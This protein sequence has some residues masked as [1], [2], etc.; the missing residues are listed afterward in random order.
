MSEAKRTFSTKLF[1]FSGSFEVFEHHCHSFLWFHNTRV[2][3][4]S[5]SKVR[6]QNISE[7]SSLL[8]CSAQRH[9]SSRK[10]RHSNTRCRRRRQGTAGILTTQW[11]VIKM[12]QVWTR[13]IK[14]IRNVC[15]VYKWRWELFFTTVH[16]KWHKEVNPQLYSYCS[17]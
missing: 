14:R 11:H 15:R 2:T 3:F 4:I 16:I 17:L 8:K 6:C 5:L 7:K 1:F 13:H 9:I 12:M 10:L